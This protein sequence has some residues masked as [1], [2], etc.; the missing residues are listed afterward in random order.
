MEVDIFS[1]HRQ[2]F[3]EVRRLCLICH[4]L[5]LTSD[6]L[7]T[8]ST[9]SNQL[10]NTAAVF[11]N[12][13]SG[14]LLRLAISIRVNLYQGKFHGQDDIV[15]SHCGFYF[16]DKSEAALNFT[17]KDVCDKIIHADTITKAAMP[18]DRYGQVKLAARLEG[19]KGKVSWALDLSI[20]MFTE[21][22]LNYLDQL[23][24]KETDVE[25]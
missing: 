23:E 21:A 17:I 9:Y 8:N 6:K 18:A 15:L 20:E 13:F 14:S 3:N 5:D 2:D 25:N 11:H 1:T 7:F 12:L 19:K 16:E 4:G 22:V 24:A 10:E